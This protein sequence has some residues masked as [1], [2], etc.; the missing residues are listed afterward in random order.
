MESWSANWWWERSANPGNT[1]NFL[2]VNNNG[3]PNN[4]ANAGN[5]NGL[6]VP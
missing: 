2:V 3:N 1:D 6:V 4:N 5:N